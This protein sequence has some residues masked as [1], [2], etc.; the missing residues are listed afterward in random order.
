MVNRNPA[1]NPGGIPFKLSTESCF[2]G[3]DVDDVASVFEEHFICRSLSAWYCANSHTDGCTVYVQDE[4]KFM[5]VNVLI[6][7][8]VK[9]RFKL[10]NS[11]KVLL[12]TSLCCS[13]CI[14]CR[15]TLT[16]RL[17]AV[18]KTNLCRVILNT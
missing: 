2:A 10:R 7:S 5:F 8:R 4:K 6:G 3:F 12:S 18:K 17:S 15:E 11:S 9:A 1:D 14:E 16:H 13:V